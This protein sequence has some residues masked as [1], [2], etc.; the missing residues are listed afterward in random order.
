MVVSHLTITIILA[1]NFFIILYP[2]KKIRGTL[3][4]SGS[5]FA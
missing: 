3:T 4:F 1:L 5:F 2:H